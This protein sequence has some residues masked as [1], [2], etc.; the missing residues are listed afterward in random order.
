MTREM[1]LITRKSNALD[2]ARALQESGNTDA[3][4][5]L[6]ALGPAPDP[7]DILRLATFCN[8]VTCSCDACD[9]PVDAVIHVDQDNND[10]EA[11]H[12]RLCLACTRRAVQMLEVAP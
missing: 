12:I 5:R 10:R 8:F 6:E 7:G 4:A 11:P 9:Q 3:L 2:A 1:V